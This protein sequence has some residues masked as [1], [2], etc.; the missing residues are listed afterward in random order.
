M[1]T[2]RDF[3]FERN[4]RGVGADGFVSPGEFYSDAFA[5]MAIAF[6]DYADYVR[7]EM[8]RTAAEEDMI[9]RARN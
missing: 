3:Y 8:V 2:F 6:A 4:G 5:R 9:R 1:K 7:E